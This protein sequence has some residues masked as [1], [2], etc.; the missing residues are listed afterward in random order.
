MTEP[1]VERTND[2]ETSADA[3]GQRNYDIAPPPALVEF[4][5][6]EWA[7]APQTPTPPHPALERF[8]ARRDSL[9]RG[10]AGRNLVIPTGRRKVRSNDTDYP[11]RP[12]S[13]FF[14]LTGHDEP[15][16]VLVMQA[17]A[18]GH[19]ATLYLEPRADRSTPGFFTDAR[20]GEFWVGPR[21]GLP[22]TSAH[23]GIECAPLSDLQDALSALDAPTTF[24]RRGLDPDIDEQFTEQE[25]DIALA[26]A[27]SELRLVKD[28]FEVAQLQQAVNATIKGF[29]D[30][31]RALPDAM[32][33]GE[34]VIDG[35]FHLRARV[36]GNG[37]GYQTI[38]GAGPHT[39]FLHWH[40]NDGEVRPGELLLVDAGV[41]SAELYTADITRTLPVSGRFSAQ[42]RQ[43]YELVLRAQ[44]AA[45]A[46]VRPG[47]DFLDPHRAAM[48]VLAQGLADMQLLPCSVDEALQEDR[49]LYRR[50]TRHG[51]SHMLGLDVHDCSHARDDQY[52]H[53]KLAPGMVL[54]VE[55][56]LYFQH[57]DLTVPEQM[58]GI[59]IRIEDDVVVTDEGCRV[60]S[61]ALPRHPDDIERWMAQLADEDTQLRRPL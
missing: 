15:N 59:G 50:Y 8:R 23:L 51:T 14:W 18:D 4:L 40:R 29:E 11:F 47:N 41:E 19:Q 55:P 52:R 49:Q 34:R 30:V 10:F 32:E 7:P 56:G 17:A 28:P 42:Q 1:S 6:H 58:R 57:D 46:A 43:L 9:S 54:T 45:I 31:V 48:R 36:E 2:A 35:V 12:A 5:A 26:T 27:L 20:N 33:R 38:A 24:V 44:D 60:L 39:T 37:T 61:A 13:D 16:C 21:P 53:G 22:E 3:P 25:G